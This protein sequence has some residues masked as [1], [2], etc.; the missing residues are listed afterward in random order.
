MNDYLLR[1]MCDE[2]LDD[3]VQ[4][5]ERQVRDMSQA[6]TALGLK[7][8]EHYRCALTVARLERDRRACD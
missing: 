5:L 2:E 7:L 1:S 8:C 3:L 6:S 4:R